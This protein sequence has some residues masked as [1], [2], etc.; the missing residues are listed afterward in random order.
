MSGPRQTKDAITSETLKINAIQG[1]NEKIQT[2][3]DSLG[4]TQRAWLAKK[5]QDCAKLQ[6][7]ITELEH[8]DIDSELEAHE[9]LST[10]KT[11]GIRILQQ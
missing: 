7:G 2:T 4:R 11:L 8:L 3:I 5:E 1:A 9:K 10:L 6:H